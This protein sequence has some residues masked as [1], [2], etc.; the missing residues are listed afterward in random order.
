FRAVT[1]ALGYALVAGMLERVNLR[2]VILNS[3]VALLF[4][5][6]LVPA[7]GITGAAL[8]ALLAA[9]FNVAQHYPP[10]ARL[11]G[12]IRLLSVAWR[13]LVAG[14]AMALLL[15]VSGLMQLGLVVAM[16]ALVYLFLLSVLHVAT[17]GRPSVMWHR[18]TQ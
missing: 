2:I 6:L 13:P 5:L 15:M 12:R 14:L 18:L 16:G 10:A 8:A 11:L 17:L 4:G 1:S 7:L 3:V 9:A